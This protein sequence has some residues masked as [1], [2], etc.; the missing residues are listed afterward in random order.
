LTSKRKDRDES[1]IILFLRDNKPIKLA[2]TIRSGISQTNTERKREMEELNM[3]KSELLYKQSSQL[4][5]MARMFA[6]DG[7]HQKAGNYF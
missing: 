1:L 5:A 7:G 3:N 6:G 2:L 4:R